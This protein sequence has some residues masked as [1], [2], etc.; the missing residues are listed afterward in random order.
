MEDNS[1]HLLEA[2]QRLSMA[3]IVIR[4]STHPIELSKC[5][6]WEIATCSIQPAV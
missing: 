6:D 1:W 2:S 4:N 3:L 5:V